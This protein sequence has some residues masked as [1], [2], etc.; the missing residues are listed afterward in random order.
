MSPEGGRGVIKV[1]NVISDT[2]IGGAGKCVLTF[3]KYH[4]RD[5]TDPVT[6]VP[7]GSLLK[8]ELEKA[9]EKYIEVD[10]L[11]DK[12]LDIGAIGKLLKIFRSERP[13]VIHCHAAMSARIAGRLYGRAKIVYTRH[14]VF[15]PSAAISK[16]IGK[17]INGFINNSTADRIIAVADA[18]KENLIKTGV[19]AD[20]I[21]VIQNGVEPLCELSDDDKK[22]IRSGYNLSDGDF[23]MG[24]A[25]RLNEVKGHVYILEALKLLLNDGIKA[26]LI[27]AG[28]GDYEGAIR[29]KTKELGLESNVIM[30]GFVQNISELMNVITVNVNAS[31]GTEATSLALLEGMSLGV[32][33]VVSNFG[34]NPGVIE[35]GVNGYVF[36]SRNSRAMY[37]KLK[38]I[39]SGAEKMRDN[40]K[41]VF[42]E[43]FRAEIMTQKT[44]KIYE[45][46]IGQE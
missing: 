30:A 21:T 26:K 14:S 22:K 18:A 12:S 25:A 43:R 2:N 42:N 28:S 15:E 6:V 41:R 31:F 8:A 3:L 7:R 16:G 40:C 1:I 34:G 46:L 36:E 35:D 24:I 38:L 10:G 23:V 11:A 13:D 27:I 5:K 32:P 45:E 44:E 20:K 39:S 9:G 4:S 19:S 29:E 33:A 17:K 37:E